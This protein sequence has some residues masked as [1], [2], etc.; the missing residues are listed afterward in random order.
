MMIKKKYKLRKVQ[1]EKKS[2]EYTTSATFNMY[3]YGS[4][5]AFVSTYSAVC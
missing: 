4:E 5:N 1:I 2:I 3:K